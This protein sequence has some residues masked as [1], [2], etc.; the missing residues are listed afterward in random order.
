MSVEQIQC[1][2]LDRAV[3]VIEPDL[4]IWTAISSLLKRDF[5]LV[6]F[7]RNAEHASVLF[8]RFN[9]NLCIIELSVI[10]DFCSFFSLSHH[11]VNQDYAPSHLSDKKTQLRFNS[12]P[13]APC[14]AFPQQF[15]VTSK[16]HKSEDIL[17]AIRKGACDYI[18]KPINALEMNEVISRWLFQ[19]SVIADT[20]VEDNLTFST[21]E[22]TPNSLFSFFIGDSIAIQQVKR[23]L[24]II[25][26]TGHALLLEGE[27]GTGKKFAF[28]QLQQSLNSPTD[29]IMIDCR[30]LSQLDEQQI[31][32]YCANSKLPLWLVFNHI[33]ELPMDKQLVLLIILDS[34]KIYEQIRLVSMSATRLFSRVQKGEFLIELYYRLAEF[35]V[36]LPPLHQR[37]EDIVI[38]TKFFINRCLMKSAATR[39]E[40]LNNYSQWGV[41][42]FQCLTEYYWPGNIQELKNTIEQCL[43]LNIAPKEYMQR[44]ATTHNQHSTNPL[45]TSEINS[46]QHYLPVDWDLKSIEKAHI[47]RVIKHY[48]GNKMLAAEHL[49]VSRK[50]ID[51]KIKEWDL[52]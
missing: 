29:L 19:Q 47:T 49:G 24:T 12:I 26:S 22:K 37:S 15:I 45:E 3:L 23:T 6:E 39:K 46:G 48:G 42:D 21:Q 33:A 7:A 2:K 14:L 11:A 20:S 44:L 41:T 32:F 9:F 30:D 1:V 51:R 52:D 17:Y 13:D 35:I 50:T 40:L 25:R 27:V 38:L 16:S 43:L 34:I 4:S 28:K 8:Q 31:R 36:V 18:V 10:D 5:V